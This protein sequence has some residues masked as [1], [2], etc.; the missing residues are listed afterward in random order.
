[1]SH[2]LSAMRLHWSQV[3]LLALPLT[4]LLHEAHVDL[5]NKVVTSPA[6]MCETKLHLIF[7]GIGVMVKDVLKLTGKWWQHSHDLSLP[8]KATLAKILSCSSSLVRVKLVQLHL[9]RYFKCQIRDGGGWHDR[10]RAADAWEKHF[11][12]C[13]DQD[14][15]FNCT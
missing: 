6:F 8:A 3:I 12:D 11:R 13:W 14:L 7:D 15:H 2:Y 10:T 1:M 9:V 4:L 5:K